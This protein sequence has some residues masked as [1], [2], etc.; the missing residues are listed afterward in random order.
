MWSRPQD[1]I[2]SRPQDKVKAVPAGFTEAVTTPW[3]RAR[4]ATSVPDIA[5]IAVLRREIAECA[6]GR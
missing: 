6:V 2:R 5:Q 3:K 1:R 4:D